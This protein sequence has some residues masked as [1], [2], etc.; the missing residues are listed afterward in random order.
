MQPFFVK[1][2]T[3]NPR[4]SPLTPRKSPNPRKNLPSLLISSPKHSQPIPKTISEISPEGSP[5]TPRQNNLHPQ[6]PILQIPHTPYPIPRKISPPSSRKNP[7][8]TL[9]KSPRPPST[10]PLRSRS[11]NRHQKIRPSFAPQIPLPAKP[12][13]TPKNRPPSKPLASLASLAR[14]YFSPGHKLAPSSPSSK[15]SSIINLHES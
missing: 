14:T 7:P 15:A 1:T 13:T 11:L 9:Q 10:I 8:P 2:T 4:K 3:R 6:I 12:P 5:Q